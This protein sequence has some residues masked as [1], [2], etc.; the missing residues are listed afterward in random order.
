MDNSSGCLKAEKD[1]QMST[2]KGQFFQIKL[3][4]CDAYTSTYVS[5]KQ[6]RRVPLS[7]IIRQ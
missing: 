1:I 3:I 5:I 6:H 7:V 4:S 2:V